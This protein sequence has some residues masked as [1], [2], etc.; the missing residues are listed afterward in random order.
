MLHLNRITPTRQDI[1]RSAM[2]YTRV[3]LAA[4]TDATSLH[5]RHVGRA[6]GRVKPAAAV[7]LAHFFDAERRAR[8]KL[9]VGPFFDHHDIEAPCRQG[10]SGY[11]PARARS[12]HSY[13]APDKLSH[14]R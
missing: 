7:F 1:C 12:D 4:A 13:L 6:Q 10:R 2:V 3:D 11:G 8:V 14:H 5:K 9:Q